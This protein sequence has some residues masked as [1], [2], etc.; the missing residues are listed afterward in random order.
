MTAAKIRIEFEWLLHSVF[1]AISFEMHQV[2]PVWC[3]FLHT[4][5]D[6]L[7]CSAIYL[8]T[9]PNVF[10]VAFYELEY[11]NNPC[12]C[13]KRKMFI[14]QKAVQNRITAYKLYLILPH[15]SCSLLWIWK[16]ISN[17]VYELKNSFA[18]DDNSN[19]KTVCGERYPYMGI[20]ILLP[21]I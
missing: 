7:M 16:K 20:D 5:I 15:V 10:D 9:L 21:F 6:N 4:L 19:L 18:I 13:C 1:F 2:T 14:I 11:E 8:L 3:H 12:I 17:F